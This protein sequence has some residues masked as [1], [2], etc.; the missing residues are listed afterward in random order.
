[1]PAAR[2]VKDFA[3]QRIPDIAKWDPT[4][5]ER[6]VSLLRPIAK[7]YFR[8]ETRNVARILAGGALLLSNHCGGPTTTDL[9]TFAL[10]FYDKFGY[11]GSPWRASTAASPH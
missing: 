6:V 8:S 10:H 2:L 4:L 5:N 1:M 3:G 11:D 9:P 7:H